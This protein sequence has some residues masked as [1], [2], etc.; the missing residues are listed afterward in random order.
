M[1][2]KI[3]FSWPKFKFDN[4]WSLF[5]DRDGVINERLPGDYIKNWEEFKFLPRVLTSLEVFSISFRRIFVVTNQAGIE[6][7]ILNHEI[8]K[9]IHNHMMEYIQ[10]HGGRID[11]IYYCPFKA[12][13]DPLCRKPNPGMALQAKKEFPDIEFKKCIMVG[14]S[15]SDIEFGNNLGMKT[16]LVGNK[17]DNLFGNKNSFPDCRLAS[18]PDLAN[19]ITGML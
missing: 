8:L 13:L 9:D 15:D 2:T 12:D 19:Y 14:D 18:L 4:S 3:Q 16:I 1:T 11:E 10:F 5:L 7:G 6:K 17:G